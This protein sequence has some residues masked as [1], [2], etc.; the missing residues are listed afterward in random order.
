MF[1]EVSVA[2]SWVKKRL[3]LSEL[4]AVIFFD[5]VVVEALLQALQPEAV[6]ETL[7][8]DLVHGGLLYGSVLCRPIKQQAGDALHH[9]PVTFS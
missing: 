5:I 7:I 3:Q 1:R 8:Q 2:G 4:E 6:I 9:R